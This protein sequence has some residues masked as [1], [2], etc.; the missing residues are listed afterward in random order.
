MKTRFKFKQ[1]V[2]SR[3]SNTDSDRDNTIWRSFDRISEFHLRKLRKPKSKNCFLTK[4]FSVIFIIKNMFEQ[5][6][7]FKRSFQI[8]RLIQKSKLVEL[9]FECINTFQ[10][11]NS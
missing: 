8:L 10:V 9:F 11:L 1:K 5:S 6:K 7:F 2:Q 4:M 3:L